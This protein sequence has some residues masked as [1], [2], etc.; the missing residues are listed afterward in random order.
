MIIKPVTKK[1]AVIIVRL[2]I[3]LAIPLFARQKTDVI[4][5][6]NGDRFTGEIKG[7]SGGVLR[8]DLDYVDGT[9]SFQWLKV[10]RVESI[11]LFLVQTQDGKVYTGTIATSESTGDRPVSLQLGEVDTDRKVPIQQSRVVKLTETSE[12]FLRRLSGSM[13]IGSGYTK[14][15]NT[16]QYNLGSDLEYRR[17][18]WGLRADFDSSLSSSTGANTSTRNQLNMSGYR[19]MPWSNYFYSG[20]GGLLQSSVQGISPQTSLGAG[21]GRFLKNTNR[22]R[23]TLLGGMVWQSTT[24]DTSISSVAK[25][26]VYGGVVT[27]D[28]EVFLFKKTNLNFNGSVVPA[29]SDPGRVFYKTNASYYLKFFGDFSWNVSFY[30][31]WDTKPPPHFSGGD[32]GYSSGLKWTFNK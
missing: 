28:V 21:V 26:Q 32:Y 12:S 7:L 24:Y 4:V 30:G 15:N 2:T 22:S 16:T 29:I 1:V 18:R 19:L 13:L 8:V 25:Q 11:Q 17:E 23:I 14:G 5:M 20:F 9:M 31:N 6:E 3:L 10:A 27:A